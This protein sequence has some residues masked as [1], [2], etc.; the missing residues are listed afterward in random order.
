MGNISIKQALHCTVIMAVSLWTF[1][2]KPGGSS[3]GQ[4]SDTD[5]WWTEEDRQ[6]IIDGL[7]RT[8][9][10]LRLEIENL[11]DEQWNFREAPDR[12]SIAEIVEHLE[13]Q[14]QLHYREITAVS[15]A[16]QYLEFRTITGGQDQYFSN[17]GTDTTRGKAQWFLEP[18]GR[19]CSK[20][21]GENAFHRARGKLVEFVE[22]TEID[23]RKQFTF[24]TPVAGKD[25]SAL[26][27]GQVRDLHQL[28]LTGIAH[29]DRH[30]RQIRNIKQHQDFPE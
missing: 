10:A 8:T 17:Y 27:I 26:R 29:T 30:L 12:W 2:C 11:T 1:G 25:I 14:N 24:R 9:E 3:S 13:M 21:E 28:L 20:E 15:N 6:L 23:L 5:R 4:S 7:N 18:L 22:K 19:F 16:P